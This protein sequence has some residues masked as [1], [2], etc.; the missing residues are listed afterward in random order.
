MEKPQM[1]KYGGFLNHGGS[2]SHHHFS[3]RN[4]PF[5]PW[6][7][8]MDPSWIFFPGWY[9]WAA[10]I[11]DR[12]PP[13]CHDVFEDLSKENSGIVGIIYIYMIISINIVKH[14]CRMGI[15]SMISRWYTVFS[16]IANETIWAFLCVFQ[17]TRN[18]TTPRCLVFY[19][20]NQALFG[21]WLLFLSSWLFF[22]SWESSFC[23]SSHVIYRWSMFHSYVI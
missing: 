14:C 3:F 7:T 10:R 18:D 23:K 8:S 13:W 19:I 5:R 6:K 12:K 20:F 17:G 1:S 11:F 22:A 16:T 21:R 2:P 15:I 9:M 4:H